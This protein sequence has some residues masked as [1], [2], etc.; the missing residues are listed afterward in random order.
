M[1]IIRTIFI[2]MAFMLCAA[3]TGRAANG[4]LTAREAAT[5]VAARPDGV[6]ARPA[7]YVKT[8]LPAWGMLWTNVAVEA[9][10]HPHISVQLPVYYSGFNY[11]TGKVKFRTFTIQPEARY[12]FGEKDY[13]RKAF[14]GVHFGLG[15]YN[16]AFGG[17]TRYQDHNRRTPAI[18]GGISGGYR[19]SFTADPRWKMEASL[20]LGCYRLDYDHLE[21]RHNGPVKGRTRRTFFGIDQVAL[22]VSYSF[23]MNSRKGGR[24]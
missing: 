18:G 9:D 21:N 20:G 6:S 16:V 4:A 8:N 24:K 11:F 10:V 1:I 22:S 13:T 7:W 3:L 23:D 19:F 14:V 5:A 15:W 12:W 2:T 17:D